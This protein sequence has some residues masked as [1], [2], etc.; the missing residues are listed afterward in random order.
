ME[1]RNNNVFVGEREEEIE[2][3]QRQCAGENE[4][5]GDTIQ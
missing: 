1:K 3:I 2:T 4:E 5:A